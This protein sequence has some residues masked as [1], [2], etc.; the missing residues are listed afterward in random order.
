MPAQL[1]AGCDALAAEQAAFSAEQRQARS[2][3]AALERSRPNRRPK[4]NACNVS[5]PKSGNPSVIAASRLSKK[6]QERTEDIEMRWAELQA[7]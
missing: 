3:L 6:L 4:S 1:A 7:R 5:S 2:E